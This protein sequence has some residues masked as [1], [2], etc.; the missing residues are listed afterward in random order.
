MKHFGLV[1]F[2]LMCAEVRMHFSAPGGHPEA[3]NSAWSF[4]LTPVKSAQKSGLQGPL[5]WFI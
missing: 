5:D 2:H 4:L 3:G 1:S